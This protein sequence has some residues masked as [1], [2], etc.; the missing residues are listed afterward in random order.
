MPLP[1]FS[2]KSLLI[3]VFAFLALKIFAVCNVAGPVLTGFSR[4]R[5]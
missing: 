4:G 3:S 5:L 2:L 1:N